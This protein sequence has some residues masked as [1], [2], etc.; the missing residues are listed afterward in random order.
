[1]GSTSSS[2]L[3][4]EAKKNIDQTSMEDVRKV[5]KLLIDQG[6]DTKKPNR[7]T[8]QQCVIALEATFLLMPAAKE[9]EQCFSVSTKLM[10]QMHERCKQFIDLACSSCVNIARFVDTVINVTEDAKAE[11][12]NKGVIEYHSMEDDAREFHSVIQAGEDAEALD[13]FFHFEIDAQTMQRYQE[14]D[15]LLSMLE[16]EKY[17]SRAVRIDLAKD[18]N[19]ALMN[20]CKVEEMWRVLNDGFD[21][22]FAGCQ[23]DIYGLDVDALAQAFD[24]FDLN[25]SFEETRQIFNEATDG[26]E[27]KLAT[28]ENVLCGSINFHSRLLQH[29]SDDNA[30]LFMRSEFLC[31]L[32][33]KRIQLISAFAKRISVGDGE[34]IRLKERSVVAVLSGSLV[35]K[36]EIDGFT[37]TVDIGRDDVVGESWCI[38]D[39]AKIA[40]IES[41]GCSVVV[42]VSWREFAFL[43]ELDPSLHLTFA[44]AFT[45]TARNTNATTKMKPFEAESLK[46]MGIAKNDK[47]GASRQKQ[48][49]APRT[50]GLETNIDEFKEFLSKS[51]DR[52]E[53]D[54]AVVKAMEYS[55]GRCVLSL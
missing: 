19:R 53:R 23:E 6:L 3:Y 44:S 8:Q 37:E 38:F 28:A 41:T 32:T 21:E 55:R 25:F 15:D 20:L 33:W 51:D 4:R 49:K 46:K 12:T 50:T 34:I 1:M 17:S 54:F 9:I 39:V 2:E 29:E 35:V 13:R 52:R 26:V 48:A 18:F 30:Q 47:H 24:Y 42:L 7:A 5:I 36:Y 45:D 43:F 10:R 14:L 11:E 31:Q 22:F 16:L 27:V 40:S